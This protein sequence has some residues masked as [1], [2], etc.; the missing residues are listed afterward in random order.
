MGG[1]KIDDH[2][3]WVGSKPSGKVFPDGAKTKEYT[4]AE[5]AGD[6]AQYEDTTE[7]IK[8]TQEEG[9]GKVKSHPMKPGYRY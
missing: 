1:R 3:S 2:S 5:G 9:K 4:S 8:R 7:R 6:I